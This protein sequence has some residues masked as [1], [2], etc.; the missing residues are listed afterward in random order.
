[1]AN[2]EHNMVSRMF[3]LIHNNGIQIDTI[4]NLVFI[5]P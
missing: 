1:M 2:K 4:I 3:E 5:G